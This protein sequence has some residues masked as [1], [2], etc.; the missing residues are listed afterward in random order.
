MKFNKSKLNVVFLV[1]KYNY[2]RTFHPED[3]NFLRSF[4]NILNDGMLTDKIDKRYMADSIA[5][6][7]AC[8]TCWGTP[9]L[10]KQILEKASDL[11]VIA[12][13][14]GTPK[15]IVTDAVW[16]R[17]IR[18]FT[19]APIIA[20]DVAETTLGA[21]IYSLKCM[22]QHDNFVRKGVWIDDPSQ[23]DS[24]R[25]SMYR[26][27]YRL[28]I[29]IVS[30]SHVGKNLAGMLKPFGV[31][32]KLFDPYITEFAAKELGTEKVTLKELMSTS[33]VVTLHSPNIPETFHLIDKEKLALMKNGALFVNTSRG[34]IVDED[35][36]IREL[37]TGRIKAYL[38]VYNEEPLPKESALHKLDNVLLTPHISGGQTVN[39][40]YERGNY[41]IQQLY[42]YHNTGFLQYET[43]RDMM[44][45]IA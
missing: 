9:E 35:A 31:R 25:E 20:I 13:A 11:R 28:T 12:H 17:N 8:I 18:V 26:L 15:S 22:Y 29:G 34:Q 30:A 36:L 21:I 16:E 23:I 32:I 42:S 5:G 45:T 27:N 37:Q 14:A 1:D 38:D 3:L 10:D 40:G 7:E 43:N 33:D 41:I 24:Q 39:G 6:A 4:S 2:R 19:A 44:S